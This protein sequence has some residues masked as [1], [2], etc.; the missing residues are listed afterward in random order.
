MGVKQLKVFGLAAVS[1]A[2]GAVL[3]VSCEGGKS[4][5]SATQFDPSN[6]KHQ[7]SYVVGRDMGKSFRDM[8][9]ELDLDV[10][11]LALREA[12]DSSTAPQI[13]DS[14]VTAINTRL[15]REINEKRRQKRQE[16]E[17][18]NLAA[19]NEF[20]AKN[21][22][23]AGVVT[24]ES[25]LQYTV[26]TEGTGKK[27]TLTD[28]VKVHY[29]GTLPDGTVFDSSVD[30]GEPVTFAVTGVIKGWTE[31]LQL[32]KVGSKY[33]IVVPPD[34]AY[35]RRGAR[36]PIGPNAALVFQ[37]ELLGIEPGDAPAKTTAKK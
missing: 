18:A 6:E 10:V 4:A 27:P 35:G 17:A 8:D 33:K 31:A 16:V 3:L 26:I 14:A 23:A 13:S 36:P 11:I 15:R 28:K 34:L 22:T 20:L 37:I 21:K 32:M 1:A 9:V 5:S 24:T 30:R 2:V 19:A 12:A 25:G 7:A 29:H